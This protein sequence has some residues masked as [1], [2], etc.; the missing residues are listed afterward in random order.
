MSRFIRLVN[1]T[2]EPITIAKIRRAFPN[3]SFPQGFPAGALA[4][5]DVFPLV[6]PGPPDIDPSRQTM[7]VGPIRQVDGE[8]TQTYVVTDIPPAEREAEAERETGRLLDEA[9][10]LFISGMMA[11]LD[12]TRALVER[13][14]AGQAT[15][16]INVIRQQFR[17]RVL[18]YERRKRGL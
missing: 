7:A 3:V 5:F 14:R 17:D 11:Q 10:D 13:A 9:G 1:G 4:R 18:F 6:D 15:P 16:A 12:V 8:W 2:P